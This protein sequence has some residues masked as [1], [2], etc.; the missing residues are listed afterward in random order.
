MY[1]L[2]SYL[3]TLN[4]CTGILQLQPILQFPPHKAK[5][6]FSILH[7]YIMAI[8]IVCPL[9]ENTSLK[10]TYCKYTCQFLPCN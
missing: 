3:N 8:K 7:L 10:A 5:N 9:S 1:L 6:S 4:R 2:F